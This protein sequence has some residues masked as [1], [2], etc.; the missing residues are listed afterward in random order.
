MNVLYIVDQNHP[1]SVVVVDLLGILKAM[2]R[3][4]LFEI[5]KKES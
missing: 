5:E 2:K 4:L 3:K 1:R